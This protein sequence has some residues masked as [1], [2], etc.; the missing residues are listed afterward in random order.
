M[1]DPDIPEHVRKFIVD[2]VHSVEQLETLLLLQR[3]PTSEFTAQD[4]SKALYTSED[5]IA[6]RLDEWEKFGL[7]ASTQSN[8]RR[9]RFAPATADLTEAVKAL[10]YAYQTRRVS[11]IT[12]IFSK[13]PGNLRAFS[14]SFRITGDDTP[15]SQPDKKG[16]Q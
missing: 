11:V 5:S 6:K 12:S 1:I 15:N 8:V 3:Y 9:Y 7:V 2:H 10:E 13:P 14:D 16:K 4:V